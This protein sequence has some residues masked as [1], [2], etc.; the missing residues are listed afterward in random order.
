MNHRNIFLSLGFLALAAVSTAPL[1]AQLAA[2]N[3]TG[4]AIGHVHLNVKDIE[5]QKRFWTELGGKFTH[6]EK[7]QMMQFPGI[8]IILR[9]QDSTGP[10]VGSAINHFGFHVKN[11]DASIAKWKAAGI[12]MEQLNPKQ[13]FLNG[14]DG[15]RVEILEDTSIAGPIEMHHIHL[16][17]PDSKAAQAW[18]VQN[19][20]AV[21]G[22]RAQFDTANVPGAEIAFTKTDALQVP[23]K[24]RAADHMGFEVK[25][26][27]K[28]VAKLEAA[29]IHPDAPIRY[30]PNASKTKIAFFTD[31]WGTY[32]EV[33][34]G[35]P[36]SN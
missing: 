12:N 17:V 7:L 4:D 30:S 16:F 26:I 9:E 28:F 29:G 31:P 5:A 10:T 24:G 22:K 32:I 27:D 19:F 35:L 13:M 25:D 36:P 11:F 8:Y 20:G 15:V 14:P 23:S 2:P 34:Q 1:H 3:S 33:T 21:A 6:N 18:Y